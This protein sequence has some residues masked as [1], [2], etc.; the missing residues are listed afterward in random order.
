MGAG[1]SNHVVD[2]GNSIDFG[3][4]ERD[5]VQGSFLGSIFDIHDYKGVENQ[6]T[7]LQAWYVRQHRLVVSKFAAGRDNAINRESSDA[8]KDHIEEGPNEETKISVKMKA[9]C[10]LFSFQ[11]LGVRKHGMGAIC[12]DI[13]LHHQPNEYM[14]S[15]RAIPNLL[16]LRLAD[17]KERTSTYKVIIVSRKKPYILVIPIQIELVIAIEVADKL[18]R[19]FHDRNLEEKVL[20]PGDGNVMN[21]ELRKGYEI[22]DGR[23][24]GRLDRFTIYG[25]RVRV[26]LARNQERQKHWTSD[27]NRD[28]RRCE[29]GSI[30]MERNGRVHSVKEVIDKDKQDILQHYLVGRC[31]SFV[32]LESLANKLYEERLKDFYLMRLSVSKFLLVFQDKEAMFYGLREYEE[33]IRKCFKEISVWSK[34][35]TSCFRRA[36]LV[37]YGIHVHVWSI[38]TLKN[39]AS[40]WGELISVD[41]GTVDPTSF[42][43]ATFQIITSSHNQINDEIE[44]C[45]ESKRFKVSVLEFD[46][47]FTLNSIWIGEEGNR[48]DLDSSSDAGNSFGAG[49]EKIKD[50]CVGRPSSLVSSSSSSGNYVPTSWAGIMAKDLVGQKVGSSLD[51]ILPSSCVRAGA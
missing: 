9:L 44:L 42:S 1:N 40:C 3:K 37:C 50:Q 21:R 49:L 39:I 30:G 45:V 8:V 14:T 27:I 51:P 31:S 7:M 6:F 11:G 23:A 33:Y 22:L 16:M 24:M 19:E 48:V 25:N 2:R 38:E 18:M 28:K 35:M 15:F 17:G 43:K 32:R 41:K 5:T 36:W 12:N 10:G 47:A 4:P 13:A 20:F 46:P 34:D 29:V 26:I